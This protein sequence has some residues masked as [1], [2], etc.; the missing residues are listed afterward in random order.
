MDY[1]RL[2]LSEVFGALEAVARDTQATFSQLGARPLNWRPGETRWSVAQCFEHLL[3]ANGLLLVAAR[4]AVSNP[5]SSVWQRVPLAPAIFGQL[6]IRSQSPTS[7]GKYNAPATARPT[8]SEISR[9]IIDRF[10]AQQCDAAAWMRTLEQGR[11]ARCI[12]ISPFVR[13]LTYSVLDGCRL[14]VAHDRRHFEQARRVMQS[15][16]FP[17]S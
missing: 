6:M 15:P 16:G 9:D 8:A 2:S 5:P 11:A 10:V 7:T 14:L 13:F 4:H 17:A 12:M 1:T 3:T